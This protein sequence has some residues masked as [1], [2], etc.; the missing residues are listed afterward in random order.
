MSHKRRF[1][2]LIVLG[3]ALLLL[4]SCQSLASNSTEFPTGTFLYEKH[5][6][7]VEENQPYQ[8]WAIRFNEDGTWDFFAGDMEVPAISGTYSVDG[9]LYTVTSEDPSSDHA[10]PS[11]SPATYMWSFDGQNLS[12]ALE[13]QDNCSGRRM[14]YDG[15]TYIRSE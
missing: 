5:Q 9:N 3:L 6:Q 8:N 7:F 11:P 2:P 13:G 15:R 14:V 4:I 12:F 1:P 10:C